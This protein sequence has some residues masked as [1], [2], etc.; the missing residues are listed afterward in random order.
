MQLHSTSVIKHS[1]QLCKRPVQKAIPVTIHVLLRAMTVG[2]SQAAHLT[3]PSRSA[4]IW[5]CRWWAAGV[6]LHPMHRN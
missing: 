2:F 3:S 5:A 6:M 4:R 1:Q